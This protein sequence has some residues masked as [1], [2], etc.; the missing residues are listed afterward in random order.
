[1]E[2]PSETY[3]AMKR[4]TGIE[5]VAYNRLLENYLQLDLK[6]PKKLIDIESTDQ[7]S[8]DSISINFLGPFKSN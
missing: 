7:E 5:E 8:V 3:I 4:I 2:S 6:G 1:M